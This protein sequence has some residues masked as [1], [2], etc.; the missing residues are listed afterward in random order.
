MRHGRNSWDGNPWDGL[1]LTSS[2]DKS[3]PAHLKAHRLDI[4]TIFI[5]GGSMRP[6]QT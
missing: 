6:G 2:C 5:P 1:I 4:P 3:I